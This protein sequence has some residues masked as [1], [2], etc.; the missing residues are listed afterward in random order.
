M[1]PSA[2]EWPCQSSVDCL[3]THTGFDLG[4]CVPLQLGNNL[5]VLLE[6]TLACFQHSEVFMDHSVLSLDYV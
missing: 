2:E 1:W 3:T 5:G 4:W 6:F